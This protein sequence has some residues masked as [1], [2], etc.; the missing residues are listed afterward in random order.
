MH[1]FKIRCPVLGWTHFDISPGFFQSLFNWFQKQSSSS[2]SLRWGRWCHLPPWP[3]CRL[4]CE[5]RRREPRAPWTV[6]RAVCWCRSSAS[7]S[8]QTEREQ[9]GTPQ[10][11]R[12]WT[13]WAWQRKNKASGLIPL[14]STNTATYKK[15]L[16]QGFKKARIRKYSCIWQ[17]SIEVYSLLK[18]N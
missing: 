18:L 10:T 7:S 14:S 8:S 16:A 15:S 17:G 5:P 12:T 11:G 3:G 1:Q 13:L 2:S 6:S 4:A 9:T